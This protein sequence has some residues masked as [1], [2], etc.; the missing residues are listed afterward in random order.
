MKRIIITFT[1]LMT[2]AVI[3]GV[4]SF[5]ADS[6]AVS[7]AKKHYSFGVQQKKAGNADEARRQLEKSISYY[8]SLYQVHYVYGDL[9]AGMGEKERAIEA[10]ERALE[11]KP[12]YYNAAAR[13]AA[14][15]YEAKDYEAT[16]DNYALMYKLNP[17]NSKLLASMANIREFLGDNDGAYADLRNLIENGEDTYENLMRAAR[18]AFEKEDFSS[19]HMYSLLA[20]KKK[21]DDIKALEVA[22]KTG[23]LMEDREKAIPHFRRLA[24]LQPENLEIVITAEDIYRALSDRENLIWALK[25]HHKIDPENVEVLGE[26]CE[27]FFPEGLTEEGITYVE[28]GLRLAPGD[29]RFHILMGENYRA[30]GQQDKALSEFK[31][32]LND[33]RWKANAQR[34]IWQIEK[35]ETEEEKT[36]REFFNRGK[37]N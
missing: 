22:G 2:L 37:N 33:D 21:T 9:L 10:F 3:F 11:L 12:D 19:A 16:L 36:E 1:V 27:S 18:F 34:L 14:L 7:S 24:E 32:A 23:L 8:D 29:G 25:R 17:E 5:A 6:N 35:P 4:Q 31:L 13:L 20:L 28:K 30:L 15:H 26:L